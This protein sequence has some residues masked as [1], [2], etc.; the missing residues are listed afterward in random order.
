M[1]ANQLVGI[2]I[3][4]LGVVLLVL[5]IHAADAPWERLSDAVTGHY[6]DRTTWYLAG[7]AVALVLGLILALAGR[8]RPL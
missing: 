1:R 5:G 7:G 3:F 2:A 4:V 8:R 6:S